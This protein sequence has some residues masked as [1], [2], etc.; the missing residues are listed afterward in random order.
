MQSYRV[1]N[2][3]TKEEKLNLLKQKKEEKELKIKTKLDIYTSVRPYKASKEKQRMT[4]EY[5]E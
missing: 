1:E 3:L 2:T 4:N 5:Y